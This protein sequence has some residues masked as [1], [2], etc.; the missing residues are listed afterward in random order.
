MEVRNFKELPNWKI[1]GLFLV[2][3]LIFVGWGSLMFGDFMEE[4]ARDVEL[5]AL[6]DLSDNATIT[7]NKEDREAAPVLEALRRTQHIDSHHSYPLKPIE[8]EIHDGTKTI[9]LVVAQD[10]ERPNEYWVY[11]P[12]R[13]YLNDPLG[14]FLGRTKT[15]V[16]RNDAQRG[17]K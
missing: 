4:R 16:F 10:S 7:V 17:G 12:G 13:N 3:A 15:E 8:V 11:R 5:S 9:K 6:R 2:I 14:E 1:A